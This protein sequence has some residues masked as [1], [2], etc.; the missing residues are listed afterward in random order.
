MPYFMLICLMWKKKERQGQESK[1]KKKGGSHWVVQPCCRRF[2][3]ADPRHV[4]HVFLSFCLPL[5][6]FVRVIL[7]LH[8]HLH[9]LPLYWWAHHVTPLLFVKWCKLLH[10]T[11]QTL[12]TGGTVHHIG[13]A[14]AARAQMYFSLVWRTNQRCVCGDVALQTLFFFKS[15]HT[16]QKPFDF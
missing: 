12:S 16:R 10:A 1:G 4:F 11:H 7:H 13:F 2:N 3:S 15:Q 6:T 14:E 8:L 5:F 9:L